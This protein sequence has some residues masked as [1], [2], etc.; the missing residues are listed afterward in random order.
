[1]DR[2]SYKVF[3]GGLP[4]RADKQDLITFFSSYGTVLNC[5]LKRNAATGRSQGFAYLMVK[6]KL[7]YDRLL[8]ERIQFQDR[9]IEVKPVWKKKELNQKLEHEKARKIFVHNLSN[10]TT[11]E[12]LR[13]HFIKYGA[14][15]NAYIIKDPVTLQ[16][17]NYGYV[18]FEDIASIDKAMA[19]EHALYGRDLHLKLGTEND[20]IA[21]LKQSSPAKGKLVQQG[22]YPPKPLEMSDSGSN[23]PK[24]KPKETAF[25]S[26]MSLG[27]LER[28]FSGGD[29]S[30]HGIS[31]TL[32]KYRQAN[33][34]YEPKQGPSSIF[35]P[36][37]PAK[38]SDFELYWQDE[39]QPMSAGLIGG[40]SA[41]PKLLKQDMDS[42]DDEPPRAK[43]A[44]SIPTAFVLKKPE[45]PSAFTLMKTPVI[46]S[47]DEQ[48]KEYKPRVITFKDAE[49]TSLASHSRLK[50]ASQSF[51]SIGSRSS[52]SRNSKT[53]LLLLSNQLNTGEENYIFRTTMSPT[54]T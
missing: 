42:D 50:L 27:Q 16:N 14:I 29:R 13:S 34:S 19:D 49:K 6:E 17:K 47:E 46:D 39:H 9:V 3:L 11:N 21:V 54:H 22:E 32:P 45:G 48:E 35:V 28:S 18:I 2:P 4:V 41:G 25:K 31:P 43:D 40:F 20:E 10:K 36:S 5:K 51:R 33:M 26:L 24:E 1:M 8:N 7:A 38:Q 37:C 52:M 44:E 15:T 30:S 12:D 23:K 53:E